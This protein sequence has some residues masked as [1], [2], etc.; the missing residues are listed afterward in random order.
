MEIVTVSSRR[1]VTDCRDLLSLLREKLRETYA[2]DVAEILRPVHGHH[3]AKAA[4][5]GGPAV[6]VCRVGSAARG[7]SWGPDD[8][9]VFATADPTSGLLSV[10]ARGG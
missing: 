4:I 6:T 5:D 2:V 8:T 1:S 9:I 7:A 10:R 3:M